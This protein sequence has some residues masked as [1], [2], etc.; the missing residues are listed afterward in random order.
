MGV[1]RWTEAAQKASAIEYHRTW[2]LAATEKGRGH[3]AKSSAS[4]GF[5]LWLPLG[6]RFWLVPAAKAASCSAWS[7]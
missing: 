4:D 6:Q 5:R 1:P 2:S 3:G 7:L